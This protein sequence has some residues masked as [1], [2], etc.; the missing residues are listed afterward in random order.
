MYRFIIFFICFIF[1]H[2]IMFAQTVHVTA[3]GDIMAHLELQKYALSQLNG[4]DCLFADVEKYF[5]NDDLSIANLEVPICDSRQISGYPRFNAHS[6]LTEAVKKA[7][8]ELVSLAN[9]HAYD[10][11]ADG[12]RGTLD[13][14]NRAGLMHAGIGLTPNEARKTLFFDINGVRFAFLSVTFSVNNIKMPEKPDKPFVNII[15][16]YGKE[17]SESENAFLQS[18]TQ[19]KQNAD[20]V[21]VALHYGEEYTYRPSEKDTEYL[22][23][24]AEAG[25]DVILGHHPHVLHKAINHKTKDGRDVFIVK[26]LGNFISGQARYFSIKSKPLTFDKL[27]DCTEVRTAESVILKFDITKSGDKITVTNKRIIPIFNV[28]FPIGDKDDESYG[29]RLLAMPTLLDKNFS[30]KRITEMEHFDLLKK[31]VRFRYNHLEG[32]VELPY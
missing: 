4:Y 32:I 9:N 25:A 28:R 1:S 6:E 26:S 8:I 11:T 23:M 3:V 10:Q 29:Y 2:S 19:A 21:L 31:L 24:L 5:K 7:G 15:N 17:H 14:V 12:V 13:A 27:K 30:D 20:A 22:F 18:V 16:M